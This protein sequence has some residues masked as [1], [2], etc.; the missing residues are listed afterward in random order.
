MS[1]DEK[2][3]LIIVLFGNVKWGE[4]TLQRAVVFMAGINRRYT[5]RC[6]EDEVFVALPII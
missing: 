5:P 2:L 1:V 4:P 6:D 3:L